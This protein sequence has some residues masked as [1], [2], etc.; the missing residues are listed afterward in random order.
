MSAGIVSPETLL[1]QLRAHLEV[2]AASSQDQLAWCLNGPIAVPVVEI[3]QSLDMVAFT[4]RPRIREAG[5]LPPEADARIDELLD[6][7]TSMRSIERPI[8][9]EDA[10]LDEPEWEVATCRAG[11]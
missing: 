9:W 5:L 1:E 10:G 7:F 11:D 8:L 6:W 4:H 2:V 3:P